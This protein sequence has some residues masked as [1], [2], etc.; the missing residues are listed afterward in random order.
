MVHNVVFFTVW[1]EFSVISITV[2][3]CVDI[4]SLSYTHC[5]KLLVPCC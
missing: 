5:F 3:C 4:A 1:Q 2:L